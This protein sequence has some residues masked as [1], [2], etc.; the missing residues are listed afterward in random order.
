[1]RKFPDGF[2]YSRLFKL[3]SDQRIIMWK[4]GILGSWVKFLLNE[5]LFNDNSKLFEIPK[6]INVIKMIIFN[7][8]S[9]LVSFRYLDSE[10]SLVLDNSMMIEDLESELK[11]KAGLGCDVRFYDVGNR[12]IQKGEYI[13]E[14]PV[15]WLKRIN[16]KAETLNCQL[17]DVKLNAFI[18]DINVKA[19]ISCFNGWNKRAV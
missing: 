4:A 13:F 3:Q 10:F 18:G 16:K 11:Y 8:E 19:T 7:I 2:V 6:Q 9:Q 14:H 17:L 1:M 12:Q 15:I 5:A